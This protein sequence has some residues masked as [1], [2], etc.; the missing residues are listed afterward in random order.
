MKNLF[1]F[2]VLTLALCS[3]KC[4][5]IKINRG[6]VYSGFNELTQSEKNR[7]IF[8]TD[9]AQ[10]NNAIDSIVFS[11]TPDKLKQYMNQFDSCL[12]YFWN[13]TCPSSYWKPPI[14]VQ[15]YC[16]KN[17]IH[18]ILIVKHYDHVKKLFDINSSLK[19]PAFVIDASHYG[20]DK[21]QKYIP[22]FR[23]EFLGNMENK[24]VSVNYWL[25]SYGTF[26]KCLDLEN[27]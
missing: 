26:E 7:I 25:Y 11:I 13:A 24:K 10:I 22:K 12:V 27:N 20:T 15:N 18:F 21:C 23:Q 6:G 3:S 19:Q 17:N 4:I 8:P 2:L 14:M 1:L 9:I 5:T 16:Q